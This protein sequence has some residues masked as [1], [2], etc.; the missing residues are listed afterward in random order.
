MFLDFNMDVHA[1]FIQISVPQINLND[2]VKNVAAL[3][4]DNLVVELGRDF[5]D[6]QTSNPELFDRLAELEF[7][8][9]FGSE[10]HTYALGLLF[11]KYYVPKTFNDLKR[12]LAAR[13]IGVLGNDKAHIH[14]TFSGYEK[15][16]DTAQAEFDYGIISGI[17][18]VRIAE[19]SINGQVKPIQKIKAAEKTQAVLIFPAL[20]GFV[21]VYYALI[22]PAVMNGFNEALFL[23]LV[24][25]GFVLLGYYFFLLIW[26][27]LWRRFLPKRTIQLILEK[28][29]LSKFFQVLMEKF[30]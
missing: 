27:L 19:V 12:N 17:R 4:K 15:L 22:K 29:N 1:D 24:G 10:K 5:Q 23:L 3:T 7:S 20:L 2:K 11:V 8:P 25:L 26:G 6:L 13:F 18:T 28:N 30:L 14:L 21:R 16:R 9:I